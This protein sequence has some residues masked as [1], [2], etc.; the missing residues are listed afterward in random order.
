MPSSL[1]EVAE[2]RLPSWYTKSG[3]DV[4]ILVKAYVSDSDLCQAPLL[5]LPGCK[6]VD[7]SAAFNTLAKPDAPCSLPDTNCLLVGL[8]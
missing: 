5:V 8:L 2:E 1:L 3:A 7:I 4:F 6:V